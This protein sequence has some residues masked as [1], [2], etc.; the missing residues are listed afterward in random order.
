MRANVLTS[1]RFGTFLRVSRSGVSRLAIISGRAAFLAPE[2][3]RLPFRCLPPMM[4]MRSMRCACPSRYAAKVDLCDAIALA[5]HSYATRQAKKR[6]AAFF[7]RIVRDLMHGRTPCST[8]ARLG[9]ALG[10]IG[11]QLRG[12][13]LLASLAQRSLARARFAHA[14]CLLDRQERAYVPGLRATRRRFQAMSAP[15][16]CGASSP[17]WRSEARPA[18]APA[19]RSWGIGAVG[20]AERL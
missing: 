12:Q 3:G 4:L 18:C 6:S 1:A 2:M 19:L 10:Q 11:A 14:P 20:I 7:V 5:S 17:A 15:T 13:T 8:G 16:C 9:L